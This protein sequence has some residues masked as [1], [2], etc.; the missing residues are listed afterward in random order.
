VAALA[1]LSSRRL[2][3]SRF[4]ASAGLSSDGDSRRARSTSCNDFFPAPRLIY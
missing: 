4:A 3:A 1:S 2:A